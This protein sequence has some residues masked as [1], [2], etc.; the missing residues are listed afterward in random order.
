M[1]GWCGGPQGPDDP[2]WA[3]RRVDEATAQA[4]KFF[5]GERSHSSKKNSSSVAVKAR[6]NSRERSGCGHG[7]VGATCE[8]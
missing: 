7:G 4:T 3:A 8:A 6:V 2:N 5:A 1:R